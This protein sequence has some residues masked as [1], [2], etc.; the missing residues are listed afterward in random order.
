MARL[1]LRNDPF[2]GLLG[3]QGALEQMLARPAPPWSHG[4]SSATVFPPINVFS[5]GDGTLV[6]R[7]E[8]P[9]V[10]PDQLDINVEPGRLT[11]SGERSVAS[12]GGGGFHRRERRFGRFSRSLQ[13]P[14]D[15]DPEKTHASYADG[16]LTIKIEKAD[17]AKP[18][19]ITVA[20]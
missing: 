13:L 7:A 14:T 17:S 1:S 16:I 20:R 8:A 4:P 2:G 15:A 18:R 3:L 6:I 10:D 9:G 19:R 5:D 12:E 11:I